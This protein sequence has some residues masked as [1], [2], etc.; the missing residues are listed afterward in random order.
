MNNITQNIKIK[1]AALA[2]DEGAYLPEWIFHHLAFGVD[3]IEVYVNNTTDNSVAVL[4]HIAQHHPVKITFADKLFKSVNFDFQ[5]QAYKRIVKAALEDGFTHL[6]LLDIDEFWTPA[7]FSTSIKQA[8]VNLGSPDVINF[9]WFIHCD[10]S[11]F[12]YCYKPSM[13][14]RTNPHVKTLFKLTGPWEKVGIHNVLGKSLTYTRG[15]GETFDFGDSP[16]CALSDTECLD[17]DYFIVHRLYRSER[18]YISLLGRGR[19]NKTKLKDN[20]AGYYVHSRQDKTI[21]FTPELIDLHYQHYARFLKECTLGKLLP[22]SKRFVIKRFKHVISLATNAEKEDVLL[23]VKL[24]NQINLPEV[25]SVREK[26]SYKVRMQNF[27]IQTITQQSWVALLLTI[28]A[29]TLLKIRCK[30]AAHYYAFLAG[31]RLAEVSVSPILNSVTHSLVVNKYPKDKHA[32]IYRDMAIE[33]YRKGQLTL[34]CAFIAKAKDIRPKG[35][36]IIQLYEQFMSENNTMKNSPFN[37]SVDK[38]IG[39][40]NKVLGHND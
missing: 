10:E 14:I 27:N 26:L 16:H 1:L 13:K 3:E 8:I 23:F 24:F 22:E 20:R 6:L 25:A 9:N 2:K 7:D 38:Y 36:R 17:H 15:N 12:G 18:E 11:E 31:S 29:K 21:T 39:I 34:A 40:K 33:L 32:D 5:T 35:P 30:R 28:I 19:L 37:G 4:E